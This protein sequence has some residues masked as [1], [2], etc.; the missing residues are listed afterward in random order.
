MTLLIDDENRVRSLT[1]NRPDALNAFNEALY[2]AT[3]DALNA[4]ADD[5]EVAVVL[6]TG[7]PGPSTTHVGLGPSA[8]LTRYPASYANVTDV[9]TVP[10]ARCRTFRGRLAPDE[11]ELLEDSLALALGL[12]SRP[13]AR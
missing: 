3:A 5:P 12:P 4:A 8:G 10:V 9:H 7:S 13:A 1:L 11:M 2:D 6:I